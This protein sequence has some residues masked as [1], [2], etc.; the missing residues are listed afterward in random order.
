MS[1]KTTLLLALIASSTGCSQMVA[2]A[3]PPQEQ[4]APEEINFLS[5]IVD[6]ETTLADTRFKRFLENAVADRVGHRRGTA[7]DQVLSRR[8]CRTAT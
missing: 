6:E 8:R 3:A 4:P 7:G 5:I 1:I 2:A